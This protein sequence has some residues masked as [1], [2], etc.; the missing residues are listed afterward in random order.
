MALLFKEMYADEIDF[1]DL[2][3]EKLTRRT[4]FY[5]DCLSENLTIERRNFGQM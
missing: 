1:H 4:Y 5:G 3:V 2:T